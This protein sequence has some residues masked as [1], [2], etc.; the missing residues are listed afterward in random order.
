MRSNT[1]KNLQMALTLIVGNLL[2]AFAVSAFV[3]P[4]TIIM[5]GATGIGIVLGNLLPVDTAE[6]VFIVN[7]LMLILG[8]AVFGRKFFFSTVASSIL[9]PLF[10]SVTQWIPGIDQ[11]TSNTLMAALLGGGIVGIAVGMIM[12]VGS[13]SGGIDVLNL[14]MSKWFHIPVAT[15]VYIVDTAIMGGQAL[16]GNI[17]GILYGIILL[18]VETVL[19]D[20]VLVAGNAQL[21]ILAI[22]EKSED[23]RWRLLSELEAG[24]TM[25]F[26][27]TGCACQKQKAV[28]CVI[29]KRKLHSA[30]ELIQAVDPN[31]FV[32]IT[33]IKEVRG[34]GFTKDRM[35]FD[36]GACVLL[37]TSQ[38]ENKE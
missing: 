30:M 1:V 25:I 4:H 33:Q 24:V 18:V 8:R 14:V 34:Q 3:I 10:L 23:L 35:P 13:S 5:G 11:L 15:C 20:Q 6:V 32:T 12:R 7:M 16:F 28:Q 36:K 9:Y 19:I 17:E 21:Q 29:P 26:I 37:R 2:L 27:E 22:T 31:A 38:S